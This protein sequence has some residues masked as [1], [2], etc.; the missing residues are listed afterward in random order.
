MAA[1]QEVNLQISFSL[2]EQTDQIQR[3]LAFLSKDKPDDSSDIPIPD[4]SSEVALSIDSSEVP[5]P[6]DPSEVAL[7]IDPS[8]VPLP[9]DPTEVPLS[10]DLS[11]VPLPIDP[12]EV[13]LSIDPSEVPLPID[14]S[15]VA[16]SIDPS[17]VPLPVDPTEVTLPIDPSE[18][19]FPDE[20]SPFPEEQSKKTQSKGTIIVAAI[21]EV[22]HQIRFSLEDQINQIQSNLALLSIE[23]KPDN[24][25][26]VPLLVDPLPIDPSEV[27]LQISFS[28]EE[29]TDQIQRYLAF[30]SKDKPDD[31][32]DIPIPDDSSK[33][34]LSIDPS[35]VPLPIDPSE[36]PL[37][38]DPSEVP[39][40][41]DPSEVPFPDED[42]PF[43][44]E[45]EEAATYQPLQVQPANNAQ[46][47]ASIQILKSKQKI[48]AENVKIQLALKRPA[49]KHPAAVQEEQGAPEIKIVRRAPDDDPQDVFQKWQN[50]TIIQQDNL[51]ECEQELAETSVAFVHSLIVIEDLAIQSQEQKKTI[52]DQH[53][54]LRVWRSKAKKLKKEKE[55]VPDDQMIEELK[56]MVESQEKQIQ[57]QKIQI[58]KAKKLKKEKEIVHDDQTI[59]ELKMIVES[60]EK[61]IQSQKIQIKKAKKLKKEKEIVHDDQMVSEELKMMVESQEKQI[62][63]QKIQIKK[64]EEDKDHLETS[65]TEFV[66]QNE[67]LHDELNDSKKCYTKATRQLDQSKEALNSITL[68]PQRNNGEKHNKGQDAAGCKETEKRNGSDYRDT[69]ARTAVPFPDPFSHVKSV[70]T[71]FN[72]LYRLWPVLKFEELN[73]KSTTRGCEAT[74][75]TRTFLNLLLNEHLHHK[76][77]SGVVGKYRAVKRFFGRLVDALRS[78]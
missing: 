72:F 22:D 66:F 14:P 29:Q 2:E 21:Q 56:M 47:A 70:R 12:S 30:L 76:L 39:L 10:I 62:Q 73:A 46:S 5:L 43:P 55:I 65:L 50:I 6:I 27:D 31:S 45:N 7:S 53:H 26:D 64:L 75:L 49:A 67:Q 38:I 71:L 11:E 16:L 36:V 61:Q 20:D 68:P 44:E 18:V 4:D 41:I 33:V 58:K 74:M 77:N 8:E 13:A 35:E 69:R 48:R 24:P 60:Q 63:S 32:S 28:L 15:E 1:I 23:D 42:S 34:A 19:P 78:L 40:P 25:S 59:E 3:Y 51:M 57:S 52:K 37:S 17:E 54:K 9:V